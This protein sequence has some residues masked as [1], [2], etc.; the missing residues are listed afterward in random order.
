MMMII[1]I[2]RAVNTALAYPSLPHPTLL[3]PPKKKKLARSFVPSEKPTY[4]V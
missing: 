3:H 1:I 4:S 2:I